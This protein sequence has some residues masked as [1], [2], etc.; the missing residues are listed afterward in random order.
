[1]NN[2]FSKSKSEQ[3]VWRNDWG[4]GP[5]GEM[6]KPLY[7]TVSSMEQRKMTNITVADIKS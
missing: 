5:S 7:G 4:I 2:T 6:D 3:P 1:M